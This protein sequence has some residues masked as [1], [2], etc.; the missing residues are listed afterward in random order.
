MVE[1][2]RE[3]DESR[4]PVVGVNVHTVDP[5]DDTLLRDLAEARIEPFYDIGEEIAAWR[6]TRNQAM[7]VAALD[8]LEAVTRDPSGVTCAAIVDALEAE[9]TIGECIGVMREV[10]DA[11]YDPF[12]AV[13]RP[14]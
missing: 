13:E 2:S 7:L 6:P 1:R 14:R 12:G 11:P 4:R 10:Y 8:H 5:A 3:V 9:A